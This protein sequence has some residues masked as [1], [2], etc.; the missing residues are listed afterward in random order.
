MKDILERALID[1]V[2]FLAREQ[3]EDG[4]FL[5]LVTQKQDDYSKVV[6]CPAIVPAN[7]VLSSLSGLPKTDLIQK[8]TDKLASFLF[9]QKGEYWSYNYWFRDSSEYTLLP[10]PDDLDDT[11]CALAA[12]YQHDACL[13]NGEVLAKI[14]MMLASSEIQEGGPYNMWLV[15]PQEMS[16]WHDVDLVVNSN[17][18]FFLSL[19]DIVLPRV[20][21]FVEQCIDERKFSFPYC[22][23]YPGLYFIS[24]FYVGDKK[25][26]MIEYI[27]SKQERDGKWENPLQTALAISAV[28]NFSSRLYTKLDKGIAYLL[29]EQTFGH[30]RP[31]SFFYQ[32]KTPEKTL[33]AGSASIT[34]ALCL[35]A[36]HKYHKAIEE[37]NESYD[38]KEKDIQK[39][40]QQT[41]EKVR[42]RFCESGECIQSVAVDV[43]DK[44]VRSDK[45]KYSA[46]LSYFFS[47]AYINPPT[48][49][50]A[51]FVETLCIASMHGWIA[52][53][54]YDTFLDGDFDPKTLP[55]AMMSFRE[56]YEIFSGILAPNT[57]FPKF[58]R[59]IFDLMDE[60]NMWEVTYC[61]FDPKNKI[62]NLPEY[63]DLA[64]LANR[65]MGY[66]LGPLAILFLLGFREESREVDIT[67]SFF[68]HY[69]I[70][71][72]LDDDVHDWE[73]DYLVGRMTWVL[74]QLMKDCKTNSPSLEELQKV[75]WNQTI[76]FVSNE[77]LKHVA[78]ARKDFVEMSLYLDV[79]IFENVLSKI[80]QSAQ[81][82]LKEHTE[83]VRFLAMYQE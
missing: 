65:S 67:V 46:L 37:N 30:W 77:I 82:A 12:L 8:I 78:T 66:A 60:A 21:T 45:D 33:F 23:D 19:N 22:S 44:T 40:Y 61:R 25:D 10:Y 57:G 70:A 64:R 48:V 53:T 54:I 11:F 18:A 68:K 74:V 27:F 75:F 15:P 41:V 35:E 43:V 38:A 71:R 13:F 47:C 81:T 69:L 63:A 6:T 3:Q 4:S 83:I 32:M 72:Q 2:D 14:S 28:L 34:T 9:T 16:T 17:I 76:V 55:I 73:E 56:S 79:G 36:I 80:E 51:S 39:L 7:I 58:L 50:P 49:I 5:C 52:Y 26:E 31:Y 1:G 59:K 24:R 29:K 42:T 20:D 62:E